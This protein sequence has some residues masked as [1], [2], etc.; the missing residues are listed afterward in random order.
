MGEGP[1]CKRSSQSLNAPDLLSTGGG[2]VS[3]YPTTQELTSKSHLKHEKSSQR[4]AYAN[5]QLSF[6]YTTGDFPVSMIGHLRAVTADELRDL[7][8]KPGSIKEF[9]HGKQNENSGSAKAALL[10]VQEIAMQAK[11]TGKMA[12]P[13]DS[14]KVREQILKELESAMAKRPSGIPSEAA[15]SLEK[16]WHSLH[17]LLTGNVWETDSIL[18]KTILGG[19]EIGPDIGYGPARFLR[20]DEV[21]EIA[22]ALK[23]LS[24]GDLAKRFDL[25]AMVAAKVYACHN[26]GE[27]ELAQDY[28]AQ[29][30]AYYVKAAKR[31]DAMILYLD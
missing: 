1:Q 4:L 25:Q 17:Y 6:T 21:K 9:L 10:R 27:L 2:S 23:K 26:E 14:E 11:V 18:G 16:S 24:K 22:T 5:L 19:N 12:D 13:K 30:V 28:F 3:D 8:D 20:P 31:G 29:V 7:Q 15:L